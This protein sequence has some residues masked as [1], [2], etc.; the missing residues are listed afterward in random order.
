MRLWLLAVA[1]LALTV[2]L[3]ACGGSGSGNSGD[4]GS[5]G[6]GGGG[7]VEASKNLN[8]AGASFPDPVYQ[9]MFQVYQPGYWRAGTEYDPVGSGGGRE[10]FINKTVDFAGSDAPMSADEQKQAGGKPLHVPTVGGAVVL[11]YNVP[12]LEGQPPLKLT[13]P[14]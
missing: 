2:V 12:D 1:G 9:K 11:A 13:G 5:T 14:K 8:G 3:A 7:S 6:S 10:E 4:S